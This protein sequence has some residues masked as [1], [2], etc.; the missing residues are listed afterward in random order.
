MGQLS[1]HLISDSGCDI[2]RETHLASG[3]LY[4]I[5]SR[6]ER[7]GWFISRWEVDDPEKLRIPR[8]RFYMLTGLGA[9]KAAAE[10]PTPKA[11]AGWPAWA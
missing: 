1:K 6:L 9:R 7:A 2:A 8:R 10:H 4:P 11:A 5:L 3:T